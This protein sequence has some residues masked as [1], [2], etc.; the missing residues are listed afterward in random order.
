[1][2]PFAQ[3]I[4]DVV[5]NHTAELDDKNPYLLSFRGIDNMSYYMVDPSQFVQVTWSGVDCA[6]SRQHQCADWPVS[7]TFLS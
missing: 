2:Q 7:A 5:Y 4:L 6:L 1:M 3:V